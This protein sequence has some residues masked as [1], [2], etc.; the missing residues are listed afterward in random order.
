M[1]NSNE[2]EL[3]IFERFAR[4]LLHI[5]RGDLSVIQN[6]LAY[7]SAVHGEEHVRSSLGR[8]RSVAG[9]LSSL[10]CARVPAPVEPIPVSSVL[11]GWPTDGALEEWTLRGERESLVSALTALPELLGARVEGA[12]IASSALRI[13]MRHRAAVVGKFNSL[14]GFVSAEV[15]ELG[16]I[17]AV[18]ADLL[19]RN[20]GYNV[21]VEATSSEVVLAVSGLG[22]ERNGREA[23]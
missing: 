17:K 7:I 20:L 8:C 5:V 19:L 21:D 12:V 2:T 22:L 16:V 14:S 18:V 1:K 4:A 23:A 11:S 3:Q 6:E 15:G 10:S 13:A 9:V